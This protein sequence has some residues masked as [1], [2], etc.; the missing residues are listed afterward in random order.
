M[1]LDIRQISLVADYFV[2]C[3]AA[4][5]RQ[6]TAIVRDVVDDLREDP[7]IRPLRTEGRTG[8]GW[9]LLDYGD[10]VLHVFGE[11]QRQFY[12]LEELWSGAVPLV[13]VQ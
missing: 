4:S 12:R 1:L 3:S 6:I 5:E 2:V 8:S 10:V 13:R 9:I 7:A 11:E